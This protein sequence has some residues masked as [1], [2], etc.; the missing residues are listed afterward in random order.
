M[1][2]AMTPSPARHMNSGESGEAVGDDDAYPRI[3][4]R[5]AH[6]SPAGRVR[7]EIAVDGGGWVFWSSDPA[8]P[9]SV[10]FL[11]GSYS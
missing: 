5:S 8:Y 3:A 6:L 2:M 4:M 10:P 11:T 7:D 1:V 9:D